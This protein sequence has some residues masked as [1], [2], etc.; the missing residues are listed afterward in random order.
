MLQQ[1]A[2]RA[3]F[4]EGGFAGPELFQELALDLVQIQA[5]FFFHVFCV[6]GNTQKPLTQLAL[7]PVKIFFQRT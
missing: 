4:A 1:G 6:K 5:V 7:H 3:V 2:K